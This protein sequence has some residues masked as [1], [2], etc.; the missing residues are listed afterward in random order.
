LLSFKTPPGFDSEAPIE[1]DFLQRLEEASQCEGG[2]TEDIQEMLRAA[3][4]V[5]AEVEIVVLE[6]SRSLM[7]TLAPIENHVHKP[8]LST[9]MYPDIIGLWSVMIPLYLIFILQPPRMRSTI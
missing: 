6:A 1:Q 8:S 7:Q 9:H 5:E 4:E 2:D 3:G